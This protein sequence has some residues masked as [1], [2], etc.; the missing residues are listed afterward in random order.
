MVVA[1]HV[2]S[3]YNQVVNPA[4]RERCTLRCPQRVQIRWLSLAE[5]REP[6][7]VASRK[8]T[9][10]EVSP[11]ARVALV[12]FLVLSLLGA[13]ETLAK[14][15]P[16]AYIIKLDGVI[17]QALAEAIKRKVKLVEKRGGKLIILELDTP[18]G[19]VAAS[20]DLADFIFAHETIRFIA[21]VNPKAYSGGTMVALACH[22]IYINSALGM[23]GDVAPVD[24]Q[25]KIQSEKLQTVIR[26][27]MVSY[28]KAR[29][30]PLALVETMVTK[31]MEVY[32]IRT[33]DSSEV[34][35]VT[36]AQWEAM[37]EKEKAAVTERK[38]AVAAGHLLTLSAG[39]AVEY[40]FARKAVKSTLELYDALE[41]EPSRVERLF[42]SR[43]EK[44]LAFLDTFSPLLIMG[45][46]VL[47]FIEVSHPGF[48]LPGIAG[49]ACFVALFVIKWSL[50]YAGMLEVLLFVAGAVLLLIEVFITPGFGLLGGAGI[51]LLFVSLVLAS[52]QFTLP[53]TP[54]EI[55]AFRV[56]IFQVLASFTGALVAIIILIRYLPSLPVLSRIIHTHSLAGVSVGAA[57][58][59][60][61]PGLADMVGQVGVALTP[62]RPA[63]K[64]EFGERML[65]V[66][67]EGEFIAKGMRIEVESVHGNRVVVRPRREA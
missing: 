50:Q 2:Y 64:A 58:E 67:S 18:G 31:E 56:N 7:A 27:K 3:G 41:L 44:V 33:Q 43:S 51:L 24:M 49:I 65:N 39:R 40:G 61:G 37:S 53:G 10:T 38:V 48:G 23:M 62:L 60:R 12:L 14:N 59:Q 19:T 1:P 34:R 29:G 20:M 55:G 47:L 28:A 13:S 54:S 5:H 42:M 36:K 16:D 32:S 66:V 15:T 63:G 8:T 11:C 35:Y 22:E 26:E 25:L 52:Q 17:N 21:Y 57:I 4:P 45:G 46:I 6:Q 9:G 30:Y